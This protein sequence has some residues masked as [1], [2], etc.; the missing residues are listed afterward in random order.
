MFTANLIYLFGSYCYHHQYAVHIINWKKKKYHKQINGF[1]V[2]GVRVTHAKIDLPHNQLECA[3]QLWMELIQSACNWSFLFNIF[4]SL[5]LIEF[6]TLTTI[7]NLNCDC[8]FAF[9]LI[10]VNHTRLGES[11]SCYT[12]LKYSIMVGWWLNV[13]IRIF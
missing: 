6:C 11:N 9:N 10:L 12:T 2:M 3:R 5:N 13:K 8:Y 1:N 7:Q 4:D